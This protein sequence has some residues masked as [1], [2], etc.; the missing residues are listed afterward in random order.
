MKNVSF[1]S[2]SENKISIIE[3]VLT[4]FVGETTAERP[5]STI[6]WF[7]KGRDGSFTGSVLPVDNDTLSITRSTFNHSFD[8]SQNA[9]ELYCTAVNINGKEPVVSNSKELNVLCK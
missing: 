4:Q 1:V 7:V 8:R 5:R 6:E 9:T 2:P 3:N